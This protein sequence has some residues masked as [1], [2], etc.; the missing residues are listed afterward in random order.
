MG[1]PAGP[2]GGGTPVGTAGGAPV[3]RVRSP[4]RRGSVWG[5][6][7][8]LV[9]GAAVGPGDSEGGAGAGSDPG[10]TALE[11]ERVG[12][13]RGPLGERRAAGK[14]PGGGAARLGAVKAKV[15]SFRNSSPSSSPTGGG[16]GEGLKGSALVSSDGRAVYSGTEGGEVL[17]W[18][19]RLGKGE[20]VGF[21]RGHHGPVTC[22]RLLACA[23]PKAATVP[24]LFS[25][26][27]D[28]T[29][30]LWDPKERAGSN[31][32]IQVEGVLLQTLE[33]SGGTVCDMLVEGGFL[34]SGGTD[35]SVRM[36]QT[37]GAPGSF[38]P[39]YQAYR[40]L[41][42]LPAG[43]W[44][45]SLSFNRTDDVLDPG[46]LYV[47]DDA[48]GAF[49]ACPERS[50]MGATVWDQTCRTSVFRRAGGR[51]VIRVK[52]IAEEQ[53]VITLS[54]DN[55]MRIFDSK[56]GQLFYSVENPY[57]CPFSCIGW[58]QRH[59]QVLLADKGG[60][61]FVWDL[62]SENIV[63]E[64]RIFQ[65]PVI[66]LAYREGQDEVILSS[67]SCIE[68]WRI[69]RDTNY[70]VIPDGHSGPV[71][72]IKAGTGR[73]VPLARIA[74]GA[75]A[76]GLGREGG[77]GG[78]ERA[79]QGEPAA[80]SQ[81]FRVISAS[82][83]NSIR[84][85]DPYD[86]GCTR[87]LYEHDSEV[88]S[89]TFLEGR[90]L[91]VSGHDNGVVRIWDLDTGST[92]NMKQHKATV[93]CLMVAYFRKSEEFILSGS[94]DGRLGQWDVRR[95]GNLKPH[96]VSIVQAHPGGEILSL[97]HDSS[98]GVVFTGG[99]DAVIKVWSESLDYVGEHRGH[100]EAV[101]CMALQSNFLFS[102]SEDAA[103]CIWDSLPAKAKKG[104]FNSGTL[105][106][107]LEGHEGAVLGLSLLQ[108]T[109]HLV[110]CGA[111][112]SVRI[113]DYSAGVQLN[114][115]THADEMR[116][117]AVRQDT[118]EV[119]VGTMQ[120]RILKFPR[121]QLLPEDL[122]AARERGQEEVTRMLKELSMVGETK[123]AGA[124]RRRTSTSITAAA[125][126]AANA[127]R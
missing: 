60:C 39:Q 52:Y 68:F 50:Q 36:W 101:T 38:P 65:E 84:L 111:D 80:R 117:M 35:G 48:G 54:Y 21:M 27:S 19:L 18:R 13:L 40:V 2:G 102:G 123:G 90:N 118:G 7:G 61:L 29:I 72:A 25:G 17:R 43:R 51:A 119:L 1:G 100:S 116:C 24:L 121:H 37:V 45:T 125:I 73:G 8:E 82:L 79:A 86:M 4:G 71:I 42:S 47:A 70:N 30:K 78:A 103:I 33:G 98:K 94:Y 115:L 62:Q 108:D 120:D 6:A 113:W 106:R 99:S 112:N 96:L 44:A 105:V 15:G 67:S 81:D 97:Q 122:Q 87:V 55:Q 77:A 59:Q 66:A 10:A 92:I 31:A 12:R 69:D 109:G 93:S 124:R 28:A 3:P 57:G 56:S 75:A 34:F 32:D 88:S 9:W 53:F 16:R 127:S 104:P 49:A 22:L 63:L 41:L 83:D 11:L 23:S 14:R 26:S 85:W 110:S 5:A 95:R 114:K 46:R 76:G 89:L 20:R 107:R 126:E 74:S 64:R 91:V 58:D